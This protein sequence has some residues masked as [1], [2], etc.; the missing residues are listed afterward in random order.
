[1]TLDGIR[2]LR[3]RVPFRPF[4]IILV[5]KRRFF[6]PH[7]DFILIPQGRG[8]WIYVD[9]GDGRVI[10]VNTAVISV[11]QPVKSNPRRRKAG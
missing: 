4:E 8:T 5:D 6:I 11:V 7:R 3:D 2:E 10:H 1:M 9:Q